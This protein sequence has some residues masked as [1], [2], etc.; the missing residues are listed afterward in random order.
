[1]LIQE[2]WPFVLV[3]LGYMSDNYG[4]TLFSK[5]GQ[6]IS[7]LKIDENAEIFQRECIRLPVIDVQVKI[8]LNSNF[9]LLFF[10]KLW[11]QEKN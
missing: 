7:C 2:Q 1:M 11:A 4:C 8:I 3:I 9:Y 6:V 5:L 10:S